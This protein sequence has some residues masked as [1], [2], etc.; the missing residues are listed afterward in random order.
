MQ[1]LLPA[2]WSTHYPGTTSS[3][4]KAQS[5]GERPLWGQAADCMALLACG[6]VSSLSACHAPVRVLSSVTAPHPHRHSTIHQVA[7]AGVLDSFLQ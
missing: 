4:E 6:P 5:G 3:W 2:S 1:G 7:G